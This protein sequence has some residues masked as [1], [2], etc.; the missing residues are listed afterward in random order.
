MYSF[1]SNKKRCVL[2]KYARRLSDITTPNIHLIAEELR[3]RRRA[4]RVLPTILAPWENGAP[5][6][7]DATTVL[8]KDISDHGVGLVLNQPFHGQQVLIAVWPEEE[9]AAW[10]FLGDV[11]QNNPL[12]GGFWVVGVELFDVFHDTEPAGIDQLRPL[13]ERLRPA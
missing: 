8:M 10:C 1:S 9:D 4:N 7:S 13:M 3:Q 5:V 6:V 2:E 12:G 11:K